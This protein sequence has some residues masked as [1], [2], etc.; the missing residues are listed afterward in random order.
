MPQGVGGATAVGAARPAYFP[1]GGAKP[2]VEGILRGGVPDRNAGGRAPGL[3][4][5]VIYVRAENAV[6]G[7][8]DDNELLLFR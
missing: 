4:A 5:P 7:D 6:S 1:P 2:R 3:K 8:V